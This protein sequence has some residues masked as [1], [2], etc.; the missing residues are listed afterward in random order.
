M[1]GG[2]SMMALL[3]TEPVCGV[4]PRRRSVVHAVTFAGVAWGGRRTTCDTVCGVRVRLLP[5]GPYRLVPWPPYA[6]PLPDT[7]GTRCPD[8]MAAAGV[9]R[10][11]STIRMETPE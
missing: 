5:D 4:P 1:T 7:G 10:P 11:R 8:C 3:L 6:R 9:K 2:V